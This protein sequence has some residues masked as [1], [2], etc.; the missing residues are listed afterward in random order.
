MSKAQILVVED[1]PL[2]RMFVVDTLED[3]GFQVQEAGRADE[4]MAK[5]ASDSPLFAAVIVDI[6][7]P[8]RPGDLLAAELRNKWVDLP[9]IIAS[10]H[11]KNVLATRF[12]NDRHTGVL[13]KPYNSGMLI[14]AL[15]QMGVNAGSG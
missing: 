10:G 1:E 13:G 14:E 3:A 7:L 4:A 2:I 6:G 8:D 11:D 9:I 5:M 15:S 12:R